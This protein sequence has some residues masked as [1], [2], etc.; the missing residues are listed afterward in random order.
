MP[1]KYAVIGFMLRYFCFLARLV[2]IAFAAV[3]LA[4][5]AAGKIGTLLESR[6]SLLA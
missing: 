2:A 1:V 3:T 5:H 4:L 6:C